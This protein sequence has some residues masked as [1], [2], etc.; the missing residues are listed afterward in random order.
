VGEL[1]G[2]SIA[3]DLALTYVPRSFFPEKPEVFGIVRV[4]NLAAPYFANFS[5]RNAT[6]PPGFLVEGY[7]NMGL[8][9][10]VLMALAYGV[11]LR[12][13]REWFWPRQE[14]V[15]A[16]IVYGGL[17]L[18]MTGMFRSAAQFLLQ[19]VSTSAVLYLAFYARI[20]VVARHDRLPATASVGRP[21]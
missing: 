20:P 1:G 21:H 8:V 3:E 15:F 17:I 18:N 16:L 6:F 12:V 9:G 2:Q 5:V 14:Q 10:V 19:V 4:Q 13:A 7:L 11:G